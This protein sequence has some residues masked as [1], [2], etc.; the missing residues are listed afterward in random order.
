MA[1][2][3]TVAAVAG[4]KYKLNTVGTRICWSTIQPKAC[5]E[6]MNELVAFMTSAVNN[7]KS[8]VPEEGEANPKGSEDNSQKE[9]WQQKGDELVSRLARLLRGSLLHFKR[10]DLE[11]GVRSAL[12]AFHGTVSAETLFKDVV[13]IGCI[14][15]KCS[16]QALSLSFPDLSL[17]DDRVRPKTIFFLYSV[18]S[19]ELNLSSEFL[20]SQGVDV[21][22]KGKMAEEPAPEVEPP[23]GDVQMEVASVR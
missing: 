1:G 23:T 17:A 10:H 14:L 13:S 15:L 6:K 11:H 2:K 8:H 20:F 21:K 5:L 3:L 12:E 18:R 16:P 4:L 7:A 22:G 19:I 9:K